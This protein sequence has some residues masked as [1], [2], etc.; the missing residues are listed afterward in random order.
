M[1][2]ARPLGRPGDRA[3]LKVPSAA[4]GGIHQYGALSGSRSSGKNRARLRR[5]VCDRGRPSR[6][7]HLIP[8][9]AIQVGRPRDPDQ[10]FPNRSARTETPGWLQTPE[11]PASGRATSGHVPEIDDRRFAL[12][13]HIPIPA[14]HIG[15][16]IWGHPRTPCRPALRISRP[17]ESARRN[18]SGSTGVPAAARQWPVPL[19]CC[20]LPVCSSRIRKF[21]LF[22]PAR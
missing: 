4:G 16:H 15:A 9:P 3:A 19:I 13:A 20:Q 22:M 14:A 21:W 10:L 12:H 11:S 7:R 5:R 1:L 18:A 6:I 17:P 2:E 8:R